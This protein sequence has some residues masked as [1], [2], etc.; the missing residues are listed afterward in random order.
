MSAGVTTECCSGHR[1]L[2]LPELSVS[3]D[4]SEEDFF[5]MEHHSA[6]LAAGEVTLYFF[7]FLSK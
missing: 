6:S 3:E 2:T 4:T 7:T 5:T 1:R